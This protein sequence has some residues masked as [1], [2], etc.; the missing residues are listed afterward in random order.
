MCHAH[1][2]PCLSTGWALNRRFGLTAGTAAVL[3]QGGGG[4]F[5]ESSDSISQSGMPKVLTANSQ[6]GSS[7][8]RYPVF[9]FSTLY[10]NHPT[11]PSPL[12]PNMI[13]CPVWDTQLAPRHQPALCRSKK[14]S[15]CLCERHFITTDYACICVYVCMYICSGKPR[16]SPIWMVGSVRCGGHPT[17]HA[18]PFL[19]SW[20]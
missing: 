20:G 5:A 19:A 10:L 11:I 13:G 18:C 12:T 15:R 14:Q 4:T 8:L 1:A 3:A 6:L 17:V 16:P 2:Q 9:I 7:Y